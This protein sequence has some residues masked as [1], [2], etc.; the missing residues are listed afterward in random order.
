MLH[1]LPQ[2]NAAKQRQLVRKGVARSGDLG[3]A[4]ALVKI[5]VKPLHLP[6]D[7]AMVG[8]CQHPN[9]RI[10][11]SLRHGVCG[12]LGKAVEGMVCMSM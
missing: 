2:L 3:K 10:H 12:R 6:V 11:G 4:C 9:A 8:Q 7:L 1:G 5:G